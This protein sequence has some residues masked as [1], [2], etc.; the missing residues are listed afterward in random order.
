MRPRCRLFTSLR[1]SSSREKLSHPMTSTLLKPWINPLESSPVIP[2]SMDEARRHGKLGCAKDPLDPDD[3]LGSLSLVERLES[4]GLNISSY[5]I[6]TH[7]VG[8]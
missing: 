5:Q 4:V 8:L 7:G 2:M 3:I 6:G 1:L